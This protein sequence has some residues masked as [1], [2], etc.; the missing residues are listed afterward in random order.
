MNSSAVSEFEKNIRYLEVVQAVLKRHHAEDMPFGDIPEDIRA[1]IEA[2]DQALAKKA[3][4]RAS[5]DE[6]S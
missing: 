2:A 3:A 1:E 5:K 4:K 6:T